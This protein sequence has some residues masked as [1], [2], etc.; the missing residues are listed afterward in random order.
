M[1]S[2]DPRIATAALQALNELGLAEQYNVS[3]TSVDEHGHWCASLEPKIELD[4]AISACIDGGG[5]DLIRNVDLFKDKISRL[6]GLR[7]A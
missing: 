7:Q 6:L 1:T 3:S 4:A 2:V 5:S